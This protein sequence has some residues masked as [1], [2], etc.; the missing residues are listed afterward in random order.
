MIFSS[1][2]Y[3]AERFGD[4]FVFEEMLTE[5]LKSTISQAVRKQ[6]CHAGLVFIQT[7][8]FVVTNQSNN[9]LYLHK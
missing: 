3:Q 5:E 1:S 7:V 2:F 6:L 9:K 4:S 8:P